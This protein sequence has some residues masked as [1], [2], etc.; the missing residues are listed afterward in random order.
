MRRR[1]QRFPET[2]TPDR[3]PRGIPCVDWSH[4]LSVGLLGYWLPIGGV[5]FDVTGRGATLPAVNAPTFGV[6]PNAIEAV[7]AANAYWK[8]E[9]PAYLRP[10]AAVSV[11]WRGRIFGNGVRTDNPGLLTCFYTTTNSVPF[12]SYGLHRPAG[13]TTAIAMFWNNGSF[14]SLTSSAVITNGALHTFVGSLA[15]GG[16]SGA[17]QIY[18]S[19]VS[20]ASGTPSAGTIGYGTA[21]LIVGAHISTT[22]NYVEAGFHVGAVWNRGLSAGE[23][24]RI[25]AAPYSILIPEG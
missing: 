21:Q 7:D 22:S 11:L 25:S 12:L 24:A 1:P 14:Q 23:A 4:P 6:G 8:R 16:G 10:T 19:G 5:L 15:L 18:A 20:V 9:A 17:A 2:W 13:S 3:Q